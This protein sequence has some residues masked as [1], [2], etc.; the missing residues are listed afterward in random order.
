MFLI[1]EYLILP[2]RRAAIHH[3]VDQ[4]KPQQLDADYC[5]HKRHDG[6]GGET[7]DLKRKTRTLLVEGQLP[8]KCYIVNKLDHVH[9]VVVTWGPPL[10]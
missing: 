2:L 9:L 5:C 8:A 3:V 7:H 10:P 6:E 1:V 4:T